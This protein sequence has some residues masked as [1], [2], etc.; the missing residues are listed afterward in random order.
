[1]AAKPRCTVEVIDPDDIVVIGVN[2]K[3]FRTFTSNSD[4]YPLRVDVPVEFLN[5]GWNLITGDYTNVALSGKNDATVEYKVLV[6]D[7]EVVHVTYKSEVQPQTFN[8]TFK[9]TFTLDP[10]RIP[11]A[12]EVRARGSSRFDEFMEWQSPGAPPQ[13]APSPAATQPPPLPP[14][15]GTQPPP[16][17]PGAGSQPPPLP[18]GA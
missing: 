8:L 2:N 16:L 14:G 13:G 1:M 15:A 5:D 11:K 9:D 18:P 12:R 4:R 17:P 7:V 3:W 6:G 10:R